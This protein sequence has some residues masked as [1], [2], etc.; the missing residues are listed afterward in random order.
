MPWFFDGF[1]SIPFTPPKGHLCRPQI[2]KILPPAVSQTPQILPLPTEPRPKKVRPKNPPNRP[3]P[4]EAGGAEG[5]GPGVLRALGAAA[6]HLVRGPKTQQQRRVGAP[7]NFPGGNACVLGGQGWFP[8][9]FD[10]Q[11]LTK[12]R[13]Q[14]RS[15][16]L[17]REPP[18]K[19]PH[20]TMI[21]NQMVPYCSSHP[22]RQAFKSPNDHLRGTR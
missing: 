19:W 10:H 15:T 13:T 5:R 12:K 22:G 1:P 18:P 17:D 7:V 11:A 3:Q 8:T 4:L 2:P 21:S 6:G 16:N 20:R 9:C 14:R